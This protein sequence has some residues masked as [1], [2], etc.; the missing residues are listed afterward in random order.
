MIKE[1]LLIADCLGKHDGKGVPFGHY[2][3]FFEQY[4]QIL[5]DNFEISLG[6]TKEYQKHLNFCDKFFT[7]RFGL[8]YGNTYKKY[9]IFDKYIS[10]LKGIINI[11]T[12]LNSNYNIIIFQQIKNMF[13]LIPFALYLGKK[14]IFIIVY[15]DYLNSGGKIKRLLKRL[16]YVLAKRK[17]EGLIVGMEELGKIYN[18][19]YLAIPDY[20]YIN[21][22][23][24]NPDMSIKYDIAVL[25]IINISKQ[26]IDIVSSFYKTKYKI[27]I[28]GK[29]KNEEQYKKVCQFNADNIIIINDYISREKYNDILQSTK[30]VALPYNPTTY[31]LNSSGVFY[32][33]IY[34][35]K[36]V[37]A[38]N[39]E[40][41]KRVEKNKIGY[42]YKHSIRE[43]KII[44]E[45]AKI[46]QEYVNNIKKYVQ[47]INRDNKKNLI[48]FLYKH[49][50]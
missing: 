19:N 1:K 22:S 32:D 48:K 8:N 14:R 6:V 45:N 40:F 38:S 2:I 24:V 34:H 29:F 26:V 13:S 39:T 49:I 3:M 46:Y 9:N 5:K 43:S 25:G 7:I 15:K 11:I 42:V 41:F 10:I 20:L 28:A 31:K 18:H 17:I 50:C 47:N 37:I 4:Y 35:F 44:L 30:F 16:L 36:P 27:I 12:V 33:A 21:K 23:I